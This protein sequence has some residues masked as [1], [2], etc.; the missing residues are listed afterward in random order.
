M[1][2]ERGYHHGDLRR[3]LITEGRAMI[4]DEGLENLSLRAVARRAGVTH[5]APYRH[6]VDKD[7]LV[8]AI[9]EE[10]FETLIETMREHG[11][12]EA[13]G[14]AALLAMGVAYVLHAVDHPAD[15]RAMWSGHLIESGRFPSLVEHAHVSRSLFEDALSRARGGLPTDVTRSLVALSAWSLVHGLAH[16]LLDGL[17][18][19]I[20]REQ[21]PLV[22]AAVLRHSHH[23]LLVSEDGM[24]D[25]LVAAHAAA[26]VEP[27]IPSQG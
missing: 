12:R 14:P 10:G 23:G 24:R 2:K 16:L 20:P 8:A 11:Q 6:F 25:E 7:A 9:A 22:I 3:A 13:D 15:F 5:A 19:G 18:A 27:P 4:G 21:L 17:V 1:P 26:S